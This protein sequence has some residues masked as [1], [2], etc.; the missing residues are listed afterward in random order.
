MKHP[1]HV[2]VGVREEVGW[3]TNPPLLFRPLLGQ[4]GFDRPYVHSRPRAHALNHKPLLA[5][6]HPVFFFFTTIDLIGCIQASLS[7]KG[8]STVLHRP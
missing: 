5:L 7:S 4:V 8:I 2:M 6:V 1:P 3:M